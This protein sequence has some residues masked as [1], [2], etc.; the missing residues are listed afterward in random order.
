MSHTSSPKHDAARQSQA[1]HVTVQMVPVQQTKY[2]VVNPSAGGYPMPMITS[3]M[4]Q[5]FFCPYDQEE[6]T[7]EVKIKK[8]GGV[9]CFC[10]FLLIICFPWSLIFLCCYP[11]KYREAVHKCPRCHQTVGRVPYRDD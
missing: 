4:P 5:K 1:D 10:L 3:T 6:F 7:S 2:V 9:K 11:Y 8:L